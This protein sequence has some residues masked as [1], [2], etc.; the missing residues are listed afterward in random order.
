MTQNNNQS[1]RSEAEA[2]LNT[3]RIPT[4]EEVYAMTYVQ[5][6]IR[7]MLDQNV[8]LYPLLASYK[9][10]LRQEVLVILWR[11]LRRYN[12]QKSSI[13]TYVRLLLETAFRDARKKFFTE[14]NIVL[15]NV[16]DISNYEFLDEDSMLSK[17]KRQV[18]IDLASD[19]LN[20]EILQRDVASILNT[21][22]PELQDFAQRLMN[23]DS[24]SAIGREMGVNHSTIRWRYLN[25]LREAFKKFF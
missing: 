7:A 1:V 18:M 6:S 11:S 23:G 16:D 20:K 21:L 2:A 15:A 3:N 5:E 10:D 17:D 9:D 4:F 14:T 22:S 24:L 13:K 8:R 19:S 25:P 12:P